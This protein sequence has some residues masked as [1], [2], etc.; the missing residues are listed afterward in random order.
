MAKRHELSF[1]S[2]DRLFPSQDTMPK[3]GFGNLIALPFQG[4]V[5]KNG[6]SLF[7]DE[8]F[9]PYPDQWAYLSALPR[10]TEAELEKALSSFRGAADTGTLADSKEKP[11]ERGSRQE[12]ALTKLDFPLTVTLALAD[13]L[14]VEKAGISQYALNR[15]KRLAAFR[16][17][18]FYKSQAM[19]L[20]IYD[21]PRVIDCGEETDDYLILPRGCLM[22]VCELLDELGVPYT[23][24]DLRNSGQQKLCLPMTWVYSPRRQPSAKQ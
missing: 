11:W 16:N 20:P 5:Q 21:K 13:R 4:Q 3:G 10:I 2:Y 15:I 6:N 24:S 19:R 17:P 22:M 12:K 1:R 14:Y 18:D 7:V 8:H 23:C 9:V